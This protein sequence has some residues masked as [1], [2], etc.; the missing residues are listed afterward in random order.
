M[1][2]PT[3]SEIRLAR[4]AREQSERAD[5][6]GSKRAPEHREAPPESPFMIAHSDALRRLW[7]LSQQFAPSDR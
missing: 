2:T 6:T 7:D 4:N 1:V 3:S 5:E